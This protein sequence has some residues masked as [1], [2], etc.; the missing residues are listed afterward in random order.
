MYQLGYLQVI[1]QEGQHQLGYEL[2]EGLVEF[3]TAIHDNDFGRAIMFLESLGDKSEAEA[4]WSNLADIAINMNKLQ[5]A[6]R[7]YAAL[8]DMAR[9]HY[10]RET[11][12]IADE[13]GKAN[14]N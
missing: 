11:I 5:V 2:D 7:C 1:V 4:M 12:K 3:G 13:Y 9:T 6:E 14:G 10:L 8:G